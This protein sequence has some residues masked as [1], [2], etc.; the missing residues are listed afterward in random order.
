M[1]SNKTFMQIA[2]NIANESKAIKR[3]VGAIIVKDNNIIAVG[4]N[5]TPSGFDNSC[6]EK[7]CKG[8][9]G[10]GTYR[11]QLI[12]LPEVL[13]AESNA[14]AKCARS[15][16]SSEGADIYTTTCPCLEC[17][18]MII[19]AGIKNVYYSEEYKSQDGLNLLV[20]AGIQVTQI[21]DEG[22]Q[23]IL[24]IKEISEEQIEEL[25]K[26]LN[27]ADVLYYSGMDLIKSSGFVKSSGETF[28]V[29]KENK[30]EDLY[31][32]DRN[33][34]IEKRMKELEDEL[35]KNKKLAS[36]YMQISNLSKSV[37]ELTKRQG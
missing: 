29:E 34:E 4:Y 2:Y 27:E 33:K 35:Y 12:T 25:K 37:D 32:E 13:H 31:F 22:L 19:Q 10:A 23:T 8:V 15:V 24:R 20:K 3:K 16:N 9:A 6:E 36:Y 26:E 30:K 18:K 14:I 5:G 1:I 21:L 28:T 7:C 11:N 17:A